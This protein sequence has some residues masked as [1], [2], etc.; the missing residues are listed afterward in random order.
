M[1]SSV[2]IKSLTSAE[3]KEF[4]TENGFK[5][6]RA[7]QVEDWLKKGVTTFDEMKNI[8]SDL[9]EFLK[10]RCYISVAYIEK[11]LKSR[12]D[13]TVKYLFALSGGE[14][15]ESVVMSYKHGWSM[16][17]STQVGCKMGCT[18]CATSKSGFSRDLTASEMLAQIEA[19]Q[20]DYRHSSRVEAKNP[21]LLSNGDGY[22]LELTGWT[23]G[24]QAS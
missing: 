17:I 21:A 4:L 16:C 3:L 15:V 10:T 19:A 24:S 7:K 14:Y 9:K 20:R 23:Q 11:K 12:Y 8:H 2:D 1:N 6:F 13:K 5:A 22:L 18:F